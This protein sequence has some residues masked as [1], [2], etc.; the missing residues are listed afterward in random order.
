MD[1]LP[2]FI[3]RIY[4]SPE[5]KLALRKLEAELSGRGDL[6]PGDKLVTRC[7]PVDAMSQECSLTGIEAAYPG[8][9]VMLIL[10]KGSREPLYVLRATHFHDSPGEEK[11]RFLIPRYTDFLDSDAP[12]TLSMFYY[13][14]ISLERL[15]HQDGFYYDWKDIIP[16]RVIIRQ[17]VRLIR[18][19]VVKVHKNQQIRLPKLAF[20]AYQDITRQLAHLAFFRAHPDADLGPNSEAVIRKAFAHDPVPTELH[21]PNGMLE[22]ALRVA[23]RV[24]S[25]I[26]FDNQRQQMQASPDRARYAAQ[27]EE[28]REGIAGCAKEVS[29]ICQ[30]IMCRTYQAPPAKER[31]LRISKL[32]EEGFKKLCAE[33][34]GELL[35]TITM[36]RF[37]KDVILGMDQHP[38]YGLLVKAHNQGWQKRRAYGDANMVGNRI[39]K[40]HDCYRDVD[41]IEQILR[42][43]QRIVLPREA[44]R[45]MDDLFDRARVYIGTSAGDAGHFVRAAEQYIS[46]YARLLE[47]TEARIEKLPR[48]KVKREA[49]QLLKG[50]FTESLE[51]TGLSD[52]MEGKEED[53]AAY[54]MAMALHRTV[55]AKLQRAKHHGS[56][57]G[58]LFKFK[59]LLVKLHGIVKSKRENQVAMVEIRASLGVGRGR[60]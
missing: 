3:G 38:E 37:E 20:N 34:F 45:M 55:Q 51:E 56:A 57:L 6:L 58:D 43:T 50:L 52:G 46:L 48:E 22:L 17:N 53:R 9:E 44:R 1:Y 7:G 28:C 14:G 29:A 19:G 2:Q 21:I 11:R 42:T 47:W 60:A 54:Q 27:I 31:R 30:L 40:I 23:L 24:I 10:K 33:V 12:F 39:A 5:F 41:E 13:L 35:K 16:D 4:G 8:D 49:A 32:R 18:S 15:L 26:I 36:C 25:G 59:S